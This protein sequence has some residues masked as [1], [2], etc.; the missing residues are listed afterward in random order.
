M[1]ELLDYLSSPVFWVG[2]FVV[3]VLTNLLSAYLKPRIDRLFQ[4]VSKSWGERTEK[5]RQARKERIDKLSKD[6]HLQIMQA[7]EA[8]GHE[9]DRLQDT[10]IAV[11]L[12]LLSAIGLIIVLVAPPEKAAAMRSVFNYVFVVIMLGAAIAFNSGTISG[13]KAKRIRGEI[14]E[15]LLN[16]EQLTD[17]EEDRQS[18]IDV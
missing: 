16:Q 9:Y 7:H 11:F 10:I 18:D 5:R 2:V 13:L 15:A 1:R 6:R 17:A 3:G 8:I 14:E 4:K 12:V